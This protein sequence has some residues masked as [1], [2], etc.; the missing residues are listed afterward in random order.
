V[1]IATHPDFKDFVLD[2]NKR[3]EGKTG[4]DGRK[5]DGLLE[6]FDVGGSPKE[7]MAYMVKSRSPSALRH[8]QGWRPDPG[9]LPAWETLRNGDVGS[10][11]KMTAAMLDGFWE[12]TFAPDPVTGKPFAVDAIISNPPAFGHVHIA[13]ALGVPLMLSFSK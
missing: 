13:E 6:Y 7:L 9:L 11:R 8:S 10:K 2:G 3:L 1:R 12:S 5:L 4:K